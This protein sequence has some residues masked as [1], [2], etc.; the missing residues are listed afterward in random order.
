MLAFILGDPPFRD[1]VDTF[2]LLRISGPAG[3]FTQQVDCL[4]QN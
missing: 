2:D 4:L 1:S 3:K